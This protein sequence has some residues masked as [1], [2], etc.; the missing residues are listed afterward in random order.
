MIHAAHAIQGVIV[1]VQGPAAQIMLAE[2]ANQADQFSSDWHSFGESNTSR[3]I[4]EN[5]DR[6]AAIAVALDPSFPDTRGTVPETATVVEATLDTP[7][8][9][10]LW[11]SM[12]A[13]CNQCRRL[14]RI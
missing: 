7:S 9:Q 2:L 14:D 3:A 13:H 11:K 4:V 1:A 8:N 6:V 12:K 5:A 10:R